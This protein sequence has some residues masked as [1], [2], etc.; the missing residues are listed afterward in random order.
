[1]TLYLPIGIP[2]SG[3]TTFFYSSLKLSDEV[4]VSSDDLRFILTG[5]MQDQSAN[6]T[7]FHIVHM[8]VQQRL[9]RGLDVYVD[10]TNLVFRDIKP[11]ISCAVEHEQEIMVFDFIENVGRA[12][13]RNRRRDRVVPE[14]VMDR[15]IERY[16]NF[17]WAKLDE[18]SKLQIV[19]VE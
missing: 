13:Q 7:V 1:M 12:R 17:D 2:A 8:I 11:Y 19:E 3:K 14:D 4:R 5:D 16:K 9:S 10:A 18:Y 15:M 6:G